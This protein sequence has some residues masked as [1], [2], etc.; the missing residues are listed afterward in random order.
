[1][2]LRDAVYGAAVG[3]ALGVPFEFKERGSFSCTGMVGFGT[4]YQP[5]GTWSD[6]TALLLATC[7]SIK[8]QGG[9]VDAADIRLNFEDWFY[10][11]AFAIDGN[12]FDVGNATSAAITRGIG[13]GS[14]NSNGNGSLMR[15]APLAYTHAD[16]DS[17]RAVSA[18][19]H[20]HQI[21]T[22]ACVR[23]VHILRNPDLA[24]QAELPE[25]IE[26]IPSDG[27]V[28][29]TLQAALWCFTHTSTY[30][31]CVLAAVNMGSDTDTTACIAGALAGEVYG[32]DAIPDEWLSTLRGKDII[33]SCLFI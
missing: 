22:D 10:D 2:A 5:A 25:D 29:H 28:A 31:D 15:I 18:I 30:R 17:I 9:R 33:E 1:M 8:A 24:A 11:G 7:A 12:V 23:F 26:H 4:H 16:D 13:C 20:A 21:S 32:Y 6:D 3:D 14:V 27:F 19:T